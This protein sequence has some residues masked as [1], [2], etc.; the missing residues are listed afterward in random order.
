MNHHFHRSRYVVSCLRFLGLVVKRIILP[1]VLSLILPAFPLF[2]AQPVLTRSDQVYQG[3]LKMYDLEFNEA[4]RVFHEWILSN[5]DDS[6]GPV[7][8]AAAY[9]FSEL[10]RLGVL[11]SELFVDDVRFATRPKLR[12]DP[13][14]KSQFIRQVNEADRLADSTLKN[15]PADADALFTKTLTC[16]LRA[17]YAALVEKRSLTA[18]NYTKQGRPYADKLLSIDATAF[19]AYIASG[20][21]NYLLSLKAAPVRIL[22]RFTGSHIDREKGLAQLRMTAL[23]GY[24]L[25][26]FAKLLLAVAALRDKKPGQAADILKELHSRFP[27][28]P[29]YSVELDRIGWTRLTHDPALSGS[30]PEK[31]SVLNAAKPN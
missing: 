2:G 12:P 21:E 31:P 15:S 16:G 6:V 29:L 14:V 11:E 5:P 23:H 7:S 30:S 20:I 22:L 4:H 27:D 25:E 10:A 28:N 24:Y 13:E 18:L 8:D 1:A 9:L 17:D 3:W 26:P 19:D